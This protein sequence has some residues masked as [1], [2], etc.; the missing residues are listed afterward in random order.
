MFRIRARHWK[1]V[2]KKYRTHAR[3]LG[4]LLSRIDPKVAIQEMQFTA[5]TGL[6]MDMRGR[7]LAGFVFMFEDLFENQP[8]EVNYLE[9]EMGDR[10]RGMYRLGL[11]RPGKPSAHQRLTAL[12]DELRELRDPNYGWLED[13]VQALIERYSPPKDAKSWTAQDVAR[14]RAQKSIAA[15]G[16]GTP[17]DGLGA[18]RD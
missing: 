12:L 18:H 7:W 14:E 9:M 13:D 17:K 2:A 16:P 6:S 4:I 3:D 15:G 1:Q 8:D 11:T 5:K 10:K